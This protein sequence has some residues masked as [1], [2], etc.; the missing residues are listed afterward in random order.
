MTQAATA[1]AIEQA[2]K[3][4]VSV[5]RNEPV[6]SDDL[7]TRFI[8]YTDRKPTTIKG[9]VS[10]I[11][12]FAKW[13]QGEGIEQPRREHIKLYRD[14]LANSDLKAGTQAQYLRAVRHF[15]KW[16]AAEGIYPNIADNVHGAKV[17]K[18]HKRDEVPLE[19]V[20]T[21]AA[22]IDRS[23]EQGKR[24]YAMFLLCVEAGTRTIELHRANVGDLKTI[25]GGLWLYIHGKGHDEADAPVYLVPDV[26]EAVRDYLDARTEP[27]T[28]KSP[29]FTTTGNRCGHDASGKPTRRI[30]TTTISTMLK[31]ALKAAGYDSD[32]LTAHS[33]R[34]DTATAAI[35]AGV[36]LYDVQKLMRHQD[37]ATTEVY[38][39]EADNVQNE[40][41][42][43]TAIHNYIFNGIE[44]TPILPELQAAIQAMSLDEQ[45]SLL[46]TIRKGGGQ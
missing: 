26:A 22:K 46:E 7:F 12:Q 43:R 28:A 37:P 42:G 30:A 19:A 8:D 45:K 33:L 35:R 16:T 24:L 31:D 15:F 1:Y 25:D 21:I 11:R 9:Y 14:H 27:V 6:F 18:G 2:A 10:C 3:P 32:R 44:A 20:P 36:E 41:T 4:V 5:I 40:V 34:H 17:G 39:H 29:L 13:L 38:I 23:T